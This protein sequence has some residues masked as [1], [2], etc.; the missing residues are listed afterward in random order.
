M[1]NNTLPPL[2][3]LIAIL[4]THGRAQIHNFTETNHLF[5]TQNIS[6]IPKRC[7]RINISAKACFLAILM[8]FFALG[9]ANA[10]VTTNSGS[11]LAPAYP[12][13]ALAITALNGATITAPITIT[14]TGNETAPAGGYSITAQGTVANTIIISGNGSI[15]TASTPQSSGI[16]TDAIFKLIGA[17]FVTIQNFTMRENPA[18]LTTAAASNN[19]TEWGVA[20][21]YATTTNGAQNNTIQNNIISLNR[22]YSNTFGIYSNTRHT[23]TLVTPAAEITVATGS[24]SG[25]KIY[26]NAISNVDY[27][28]VF[29]G[30]NAAAAMDNGNDI[31]GT[32]LATANTITNWGGLVS[33][34]ISGYI[35]VTGSNAGIYMN[36]Q[37]NDNVSYNTLASA[38]NIT[39]ITTQGFIGIFKAYA[40]TQPTGTITATYNNN[41]V[42]LTNNAP[43][44]SP[45]T[46]MGLQGLTTLSTAT[47]NCN[48]NLILNC[49]ISGTPTSATM[50]GMLHSSAPGTFNITNNTIRGFTS[51]AT[52]GGFTGIQ[53]QTNGV[54]TA[55]NITNNKIGDN[56]AGAV[57]FNNATSGAV[58]SIA[59]T[60]TGA[61]A[62]CATTIT[63]NDIRG[64]T[65]SV[66]GSSA[67]TYISN[68]AATLS[69]N[70]STNTFTNLNVNTTG[71]VTFI[72][73]TNTVTATAT[74]TVSNNSI[75]TAFNKGGASGSI[76]CITDNGSS[77]TGAVTTIQ[78]N[79]FSNITIAGSTTITGIN[80]TC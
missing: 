48:N 52:L 13:L 40:T 7:E 63:G 51:N 35:G 62:T 71:S 10:Q 24:N 27:G 47:F 66:V 16:L 39:T 42:T 5:V 26:S 61:S 73:I 54:V 19:M 22:I 34:A 50:I 75:V 25:N 45:M 72:A 2:M 32:S 60:L 4:G 46:G 44:T 33:G 37:I 17:D 8:M 28:I 11:G 70:I 53:Q 64:I 31:G 65:H 12:S 74:K 29:V 77:V 3:R 23:A 58:T 15:I 49:A 9:S 68:A 6:N 67:H 57:T 21:L 55:L 79:N 36:H 69:Q 59:V 30:S 20:L 56:I 76:L 78:N 41:T 18:N 43:T 14:L 38:T 1:K 80:L